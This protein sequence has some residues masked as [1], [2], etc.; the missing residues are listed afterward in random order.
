MPA[1]LVI[2]IGNTSTSAAVMGSG[3]VRS[4]GHQSSRLS[5]LSALGK[6]V[7]SVAGRQRIDGSVLCSVVPDLNENWIRTLRRITITAP[8]VV[9]HKTRLG[10]KIV[11]PRPAT[12]GADRLANA[13]AVAHDIDRPAIVADFGTAVTFD[14]VTQKK[15]YVGGVIAPGLPLMTD[16]LY[17]KTALLPRITLKG[18]GVGGPIGKSTEGAM[19]IGA[20]IGYRGMVREIVGHVARGLGLRDVVLY[21]TGGFARWALRGIDMPFRFDPYLT[22]RGLD[23]IWRLNSPG[24]RK[25]EGG[26]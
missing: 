26:L 10:V 1:I 22:L 13:C 15:E 2:D 25:E 9:N 19:R 21:A 20:Q 17:E 3:H 7:R 14:V 6:F 12:I 23:L 18:A 24:K 4:F 5:S 11:Y 16:Y 8:V